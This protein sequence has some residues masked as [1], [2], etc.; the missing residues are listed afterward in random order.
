MA[1]HLTEYLDKLEKHCGRGYYPTLTTACKMLRVAVGA[2]KSLSIHG[3]A[4]SV[5][6]EYAQNRLD[7]LDRMAQ[8]A[9][10]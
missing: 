3:H 5:D 4:E 6:R 10:K 1:E 9:G 2:L 7:E 8:E